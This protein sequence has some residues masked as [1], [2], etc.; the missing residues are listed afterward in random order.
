MIIPFDDPLVKEK[1]RTQKDILNEAGGD[2]KEYSRIID[3]EAQELKE[4]YKGK[5]KKAEI[6]SFA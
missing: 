4:K 1:H 3:K 5:F 2:L 6:K